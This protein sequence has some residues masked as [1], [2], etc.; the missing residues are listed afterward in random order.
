VT[1]LRLLSLRVFIVLSLAACPQDFDAGNPPCSSHADCSPKVLG[2]AFS[3]ALYLCLDGRCVPPATWDGAFPSPDAAGSV[4]SDVG[5]GRD[6]GQAV[7]AAAPLIDT[8]WVVIPDAFIVEDPDGGSGLCGN[9]QID[10]GEACD[11]GNIIDGDGC[12]ATCQSEEARCGNGIVEEG[13]DCD[14]GNIIAGDGCNP[15][16]ELE[17]EEAATICD[18]H[19]ADLFVSCADCH[20]GAEPSGG[21]LI[22]NRSPETLFRSLLWDEGDIAVVGTSG[23]QIIA[24]GSPNDSLLYRKLAGTHLDPAYVARFPE[25]GGA[26]MPLDLAPWSEDAMLQFVQ[27]IERDVAQFGV[28]FRQQ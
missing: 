8:G 4:T 24:P 14:D 10:V 22:D 21:L 6:L 25:I 3:S 13:E 11:D 7:D 2:E 15:L 19:A 27:F 18:L 17:E 20:M 1:D 12:S 23:A 16:C 28:C 26:R 9:G 5:P